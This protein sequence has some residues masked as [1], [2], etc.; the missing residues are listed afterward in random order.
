MSHLALLVWLLNGV[1]R[2]TFRAPH[3]KSIVRANAIRNSCSVCPQ[4]GILAEKSK[5]PLEKMRRRLEENT[6]EVFVLSLR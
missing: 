4:S 5:Y 2:F 3:T 6:N 1:V